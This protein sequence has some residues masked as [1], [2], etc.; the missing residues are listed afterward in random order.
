[1]AIDHLFPPYTRE[2]VEALNQWFDYWVGG[3][4]E[5]DHE[6]FTGSHRSG[7]QHDLKQALAEGAIS[8]VIAPTR[9]PQFE[10]LPIAGPYGVAP[11]YAGRLRDGPSR[12]S[13]RTVSLPT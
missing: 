5:G 3:P 9:R 13:G 10:L 12:A 11:S 6:T 1:V 8:E 2:K 4:E 7:G